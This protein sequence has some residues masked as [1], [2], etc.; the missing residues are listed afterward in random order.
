MRSIATFFL[1]SL[2]RLRNSPCP[3]HKVL[4]QLPDELFRRAIRQIPVSVEALGGVA[5]HYLRLVDGKH[6]EEDHHLP[7]MILRARGANRSNRSARFQ[8]LL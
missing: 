2:T 7:Q 6:V 1:R 8:R 5:D 3:L 4:E